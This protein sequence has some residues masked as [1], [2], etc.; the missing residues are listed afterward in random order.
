MGAGKDKAPVRTAT[1]PANVVD[2]EN[3]YLGTLMRDALKPS[4]ALKASDFFEPKNSDVYAAILELNLEGKGCDEYVVSDKLRKKRSSVAEHYVN[5]LTRDVGFVMH[6]EAWPAFIIDQADR[7]RLQQAARRAIE[8]T[9]GGS[10]SLQE[11]KEALD[12]ELGALSA[13]GAARKGVETMPLE[14]LRAF[15]RG[16]DPECLVGQRWLCRKKSLLIVGQSGVGKSSLMLQMAICW[17][18]GKAF[19]GM[20]SQSPRRVLIIQGENDMGDIAEAFQDVCA[21]FE[22]WTDRDQSNLNSNLKILQACGKS[23]PQFANSLREETNTHKADFVFVD[24]L[25][26][27][28]SGNVS[29]TEDMTRFLREQIDPVLSETGAVLV[30]MHHTG[31]PG[32]PEEKHGRTVT[33]HSYDGIGSSEIT[34]FFR[35]IIILSRAHSQEPLFR[36]RVTKRQGRSGMSDR[37]GNH[38][39]E[40]YIRHSSDPGKVRWEYASEEHVKGLQTKKSKKGF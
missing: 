34:N 39:D 7:R 22:N 25:L 33:D 3:A 1:I 21:G 14:T 37:D 28:A 36:V 16:K 24:P 30:A 8:S 35:S 17:A 40:L 32:N 11:I 5:G 18:A 13:F 20:H 12:R 26:S 2:I 6:N 27:F 31:K 38:V 10:E 9:E 29:S 19:F 15:D 4:P 23:G